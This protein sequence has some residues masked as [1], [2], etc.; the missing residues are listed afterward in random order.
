MKI[1][2]IGRE[3]RNHFILWKIMGWWDHL[4]SNS[5]LGKWEQLPDNKPQISIFHSQKLLLNISHSKQNL[6]SLFT[7]SNKLLILQF[8]EKASH[9]F[10]LYCQK[11]SSNTQN[12][13]NKQVTVKSISKSV[14]TKGSVVV[15]LSSSHDS[16]LKILFSHII[17]NNFPIVN[18]AAKPYISQYSFKNKVTVV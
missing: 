14:I 8:F 16:D 7:Y 11:H 12:L 2:I 18:P 1:R 10:F 4:W 6:E 15:K 3:L 5:L 17:S 9:I 13:N